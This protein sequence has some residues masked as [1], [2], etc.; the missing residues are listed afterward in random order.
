[1]ELFLFF[2]LFLSVTTKSE[3]K[4]RNKIIPFNFKKFFLLDFYN[5][6]K[7]A[8]LMNVRRALDLWTFNEVS[9][10]N[11][12]TWSQLALLICIT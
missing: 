2:M 9:R 1:M 7:N 12:G 11:D 6:V 8:M 4:I 3:L 5:P 10:H